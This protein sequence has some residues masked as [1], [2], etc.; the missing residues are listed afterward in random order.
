MKKTTREWY[1]VHKLEL[2]IQNIDAPKLPV[3]I[4]NDT[5][6]TGPYQKILNIIAVL[7]KGSGVDVQDIVN[8]LKLKNSENIIRN[9]IEEGEVFEISPGRIK[10][11]N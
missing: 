8:N 5:E 3:E 11:L 2:K 4:E 6:E 7:D 1:D 10:L 9:L